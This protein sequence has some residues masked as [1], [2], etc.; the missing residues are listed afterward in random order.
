ME[1]CHVCEGK[2]YVTRDAYGLLKTKKLCG[3]CEGRGTV[4]LKIQRLYAY[5]ELLKLERGKIKLSM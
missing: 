4:N 5:Q 1:E 2:G 3:N